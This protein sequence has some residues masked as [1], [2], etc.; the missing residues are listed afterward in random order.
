[1]PHLL[2]TRYASHLHPFQ[3]ALP[4]AGSWKPNLPS[5]SGYMAPGV[6]QGPARMAPPA[7]IIHQ[8]PVPA[9]G[10]QAGYLGAG[11]YTNA[12]TGLLIPFNQGYPNIRSGVTMAP[13][14]IR[15]VHSPEYPF[16]SIPAGYYNP[17]TAY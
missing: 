9:A 16:A 5:A 6:V 13:N 11:P 7:Q 1:M 8:A 14:L 15:R 4:S 3:T 10:P 17:D 12:V 2:R